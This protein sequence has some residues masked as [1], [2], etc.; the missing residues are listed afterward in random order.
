MSGPVRPI[1]AD[2]FLR[3]GRAPEAGERFRFPEQ[4]STLEEIAVT[5]GE[6][7][8]RGA[9]A[10]TIASFANGAGLTADDLGAH[11]PEWVEPASQPYRGFR[12]HEIP[13]NGQGLA[14][15]IALGLLER[16]DLA[17]H[18]PDSPGSLHL[19]VEAM[20]LAFADV[21]RHVS[22]PATM[23]VRWQDLVEPSYLQARARQIDPSRAQRPVPGLSPSGTVYLTPPM[24]AG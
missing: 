24:P 8:Y 23:A 16:M 5:R 17:S 21:Y 12:V 1:L 14:A 22:D 9:L 15:L 4:A 6:S 7:F 11:R 19:Q 18:D 3:S 2:A 13:P 10:E 20:K